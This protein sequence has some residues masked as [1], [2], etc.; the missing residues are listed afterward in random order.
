MW[1]NKETPFTGAP[2][3]KRRKD[4][5]ADNETIVGID[6]GTTNSEVS[7]IRDGQVEVL[8]E[9]GQPLLPSAV[10]LDPQGRLLVGYPAR[11]QAVLAPQRTIRSI[12]RKMGEDVKVSLGDHEYSPQEVSAIILRTLKGRAE[13]QLGHPVSKAVITVPAFFNETQRE[14]TREAGELAELEVVRIINEPTAASLTYESQPEQMERL[15]VYDLGGGTFDVSL[16]QIER[17][18]VEVLAS[19]GDTHLGGDDFDQLLLDWV[20]DR[21]NEEQGV[22][23]LQ[24][25]VAQSRLLQAVEEAKI[26]LSFEAVTRIEEEF[27]AEKEG[28]PLHLSIEVERHEYEALIEPLLVKTL[29]HLNHA[30]SDAK[31]NA[32]QID[33]VILVGGASRTPIVHR[34]LQDRLGQP[35]HGEVDPDLCVAMGAAIQGGLISGVDVGPVLVDITPH[36]LGIRA[37]GELMGFTSPYLFVPIIERNTPLP[38]SRSEMFYT[39]VDKQEVAEISIYQGEEQ[40]ARHNE[41]VGEFLLEG[42]AEV[43]QGNEILVRFDLDLDGILAVTATERDTGLEKGLTI[44]NAISRFRREGREEAR[45]RLDAVFHTAEATAG[46]PVEQGGAAAAIAERL[47]AELA[48]VIEDAERL[49]ARAQKAAPDA[50]PEDAEEMQVLIGRLRDAVQRP[51]K[52]E[53]QDAA[54]E[55]DDMLFYLEGS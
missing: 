15:L 50:A 2:V 54:A 9:D 7:V 36:T 10:G 28:K 4:T 44:E 6:L 45:Q 17:G 40:D 41:L 5:M 49:I 38:A 16:V 1:A 31:L 21:F 11:N 13:K 43:S 47:P 27:I 46:E 35:V 53:I 30:L 12:K 51:S 37:L 55:L 18:V 23:L 32:R 3:G 24:S 34:L 42:L 19:H 52:S 20:C 33:K 39:S 25:H 26:R 8:K 48:R 14:A 29:D 22:D